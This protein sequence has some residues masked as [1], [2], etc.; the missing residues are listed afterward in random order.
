MAFFLA[1]YYSIEKETNTAEEYKFL[2]GKNRTSVDSI[3]IPEGKVGPSPHLYFPHAVLG[4]G[5]SYK[6][7]RLKDCG[8]I[9]R[10]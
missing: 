5:M 7:H 9:R 8:T 3:P 1:F 4:S 6:D 2:D 10:S